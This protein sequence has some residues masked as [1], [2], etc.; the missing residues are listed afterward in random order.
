MAER[1]YQGH[2]YSQSAPGQPWVL[3]GPASSSGPTPVTIGTPNTT[4]TAQAQATLQR[5]QQEIDQANATATATAAKAAAEAK[6]AQIKAQTDQETYAAAHPKG[7]GSTVMGP[8][9]L[10]TLTEPDQEL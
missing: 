6:S 10:K 5:T 3:V 1:T 7:T 8:D 4:R 9:F 2:T